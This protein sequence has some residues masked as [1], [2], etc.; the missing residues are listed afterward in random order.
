VDKLGLEECEIKSF[1]NQRLEAKKLPHALLIHGPP[2]IGK[3]HLSE[4]IA[5]IIMQSPTLNHK[6]SSN[7]PDFYIVNQE[8]NII[9]IETIRDIKN[10]LQMTAI[11]AD[12]KVLLIHDMDRMN[13]N[14]CNA[15]LKLLEEPIGQTV[16]L[17]NTSKLS[18]LPQTIISRCLKL[19]LR[20]MNEATFEKVI[21]SQSSDYN[22]TD[23]QRVYASCDGNINIAKLL[24]KNEI[25][26]NDND[27][28]T[29]SKLEKL[30]LNQQE[31]YT[32]FIHMAQKLLAKSTEQTLLKQNK[33]NSNFLKNVN[34]IEEFT[35]NMN[36]LNKNTVKT[37]ILS[38]LKQC[39]A[40]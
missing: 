33:Y 10:W 7:N 16:I 8:E 6:L 19:K 11:Q 37:V 9:N 18:G 27:N 39:I 34:Y 35:N 2:G 25:C 17:L 36:I 14:A 32:I 4:E 24:L 5:N 30:D 3:S 20:K 40:N 1:I 26:N 31:Q 13:I 22:K 21:A 28:I 12:Y 38:L 23:L 29:I 15:F